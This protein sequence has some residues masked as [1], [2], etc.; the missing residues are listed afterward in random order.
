MNR[1]EIMLALRQRRQSMKLTSEEVAVISGYH[2]NSILMY[3]NMRR[4]IP[5]HAAC[6]IAEALGL[7]LVLRDRATGDEVRP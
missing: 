7:E 4:A 2:R 3:E 5:L 1:K 6:D